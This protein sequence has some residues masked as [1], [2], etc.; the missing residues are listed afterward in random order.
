MVNTRG[1][2]TTYS[3]DMGAKPEKFSEQPRGYQTTYSRDTGDVVQPDL[4][5]K[6]IELMGMNMPSLTEEQI[7][8]QC[9]R[10]TRGY[11]SPGDNRP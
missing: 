9:A 10:K 7:R 1:Y 6:C 8:E 3:R 5:D 4:L 11:T 2:K